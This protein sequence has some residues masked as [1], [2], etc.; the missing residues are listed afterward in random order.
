MS[1][2]RPGQEYTDLRWGTRMPI[3]VMI[4]SRVAQLR[5]RGTCTL[6]VGDAGRLEKQVP[7][8]ENLASHLSSLL[9]SSM[10]EVIGELSAQISD[11]AQ[12]TTISAQTTQALQSKLE[13]KCSALGLQL[14]TVKIEAIES[15]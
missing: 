2:Y 3:A 8:P 4:G 7:D 6:T 13:P 15:V 14:K 9:A 11:L 12:L 10:T 5:A 1:A